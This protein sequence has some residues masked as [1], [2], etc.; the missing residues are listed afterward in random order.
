MTRLLVIIA[1]LLSASRGWA[2]NNCLDCHLE[3]EDETL[4]PAAT[5]FSEDV[6]AKAGLTCAACHGGD[7]TANVED[8]DYS[9]AMDPAKGYIGVPERSAI[10]GTCGRCHSD[11]GYMHRFDPNLAVD[12][13]AQY[14]T[15]VH[16][17]KLAEGD[18]RVAECASCHR[19]HGIL[20]VKDPRAPVYPTQIPETCGTCHARAEYMSPYGIP[21]TQLEEYRSSVHGEALFGRGD[22]GA[23]TC[24]SCHGNHGAAPPGIDTV[25]RVCG[26]CHAVQRE[27][28]AASPHQEA[29]QSMEFPEC[30]TCHDNHATAKPDD[31]MVGAGEGAVCLQCHSEGEDALAVAATIRERIEELKA[32][33]AQARELVERAGRAGMEVS[34]AEVALIDASQ[35]LV[36]AR[37]LVH[38][39]AT[40]PVEDKV[41][42][43]LAITKKAEA[44]GAAA[45]EEL[46]FRRIGLAISLVFI[47]VM[48]LGLYLKIRQ[49][50]GSGESRP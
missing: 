14:R 33:E 45:L 12:Q 11:A 10:P 32:S 43:G 5:S 44:M 38:S 37:N 23:P 31:A 15:S 18:A 17:Q 48:V 29:F 6:H 27:L 25:S 42:E 30:E 41:K 3:L 36:E 9:R 47:L 1:A 20:P 21:T 8:G 46:D 39:F 49:I 26:S 28:F 13:V 16:G 24:N 2:Q 22:L 34:D 7:P 50:E 4:T 35:S 40:G 19:A